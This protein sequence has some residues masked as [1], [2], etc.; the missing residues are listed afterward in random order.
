MNLIFQYRRQKKLSEIASNY[1][2]IYRQERLSKLESAKNFL[3]GISSSIY[4]SI[5][6]AS[7]KGKLNVTINFD[8]LNQNYKF[9]CV[10]HFFNNE[11]IDQLMLHL[12]TFLENEGFNYT[13]IDLNIFISWPDPFMIQDDDNR[14]S[15]SNLKLLIPES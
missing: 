9:G 1:V 3:V 12:T 14:L 13:I 15:L 7:K 10:D 5:I 2:C 6:D 8:E 11:E 4:L